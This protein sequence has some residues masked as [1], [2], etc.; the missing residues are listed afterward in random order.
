[1]TD[2]VKASGFS[3]SLPTLQQLERDLSAAVDK[4][5]NGVFVGSFTDGTVVLSPGA[6]A[7]ALAAVRECASPA[8]PPRELVERKKS[9]T[10]N[11]SDAEVAALEELCKRQE[12]S[13]EGIYRQALR[14]YQ[15]RV[16]GEPDLGPKLYDPEAADAI[17]SLSERVTA[18][19]VWAQNSKSIENSLWATVESINRYYCIE[20]ESNVFSAST[21]V[22]TSEYGPEKL[23]LH[24]TLDDA[25]A[26]CQADLE[27][28]IRSAL[29]PVQP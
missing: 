27:T 19:L 15:L 11:L 8:S 25:K 3:P 6:A 2:K 16:M 22:F 17:A 9:V 5:H 4:K 13:R 12:L 24:G 7:V 18:T 20:P 26:A 14:L 1:M 21:Q 29:A 10:L 23:G 28:R